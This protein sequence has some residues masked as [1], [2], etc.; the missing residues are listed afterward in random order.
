MA[1]HYLTTADVQT[2]IAG[3]RGIFTPG[4]SEPETAAYLH[5]DSTLEVVDS[6]D[7]LLALGADWIKLEHAHAAPHNFFQSYAW[8]SAWAK[9]Y[10]TNSTKVSPRLFVGRVHGEVVMIW[11]LMAVNHGPVTVLKWLTDPVGHYGDVLI[12]SAEDKTSW[13][14]AAW[15]RITSDPEIDGVS[16]RYVREDS[17]AH[18]FLNR[19]ARRC[20]KR[21]LSRHLNLRPYANSEDY[22]RALSRNQRSQ[23]SKLRKRLERDGPVQFDVIPGGQAFKAVARQALAFKAEWLKKHSLQGGTVADPRFEDLMVK[24]GMDSGHTVS[25]GVVSRDGEALAIDL[26]FSFKG[27]FF[28]TIL[29][30]NNAAAAASPAKLLLDLRQKDCIAAGYSEF[31][32]MAPDAPYK[33]HW[34]DDAVPVD[35]FL[36]AMN[37]WGYAYC[38]LYQKRLRP[39]LKR[40]YHGLPPKARSWLNR[41]AGKSG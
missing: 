5:P 23:R 22:T 17:T 8:C 28:G 33:K 14:V 36:L 30:E 2:G 40:L 34:T 9:V 11:P 16:L 24:L 15:N 20:P 4:T 41:I 19:H 31:D 35:D 10:M 1:Q 37:I 38:S 6:V 13:L 26:S 7:G 39:R 29:A 32:M 3:G 27:R 18:G 12:S 21:N 25:A